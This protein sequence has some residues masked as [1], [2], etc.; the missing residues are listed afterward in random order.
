MRNI[1]HASFWLM[2]LSGA[3]F[4]SKVYIRSIL[5]NHSRAYFWMET[6]FGEIW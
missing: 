5:K 6:L 2:I 1:L 3:S 4:L